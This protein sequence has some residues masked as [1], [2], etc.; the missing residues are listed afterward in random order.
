MDRRHDGGS[1]VVRG[2]HRRVP[3][4]RKASVYRW[5]GGWGLPA[6]RVGKLWKFKKDEVD[7][8][9]RSGGGANEGQVARD[10]FRRLPMLLDEDPI[11]E[12]N[13]EMLYRQVQ[14]LVDEADWQA[15][16]VRVNTGGNG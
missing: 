7:D 10:T 9:V 12:L 2:R 3:R 16:G 1:L 15:Q 6:H 11:P 13:P 4:R 8:W 5:I 14:F